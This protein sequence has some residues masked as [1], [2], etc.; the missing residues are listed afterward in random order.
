MV[1]VVKYL[2]TLLKKYNPSKIKSFAD[3]R[4]SIDS[5][6]NLYRKLGFILEK[7]TLPDYRYI[8]PKFVKRYH[9]FGFRKKTLYNKYGLPLSMTESEMVKELGYDRIWDCG[10]I[11]YVWY[12]NKT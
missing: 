10:L 6:S 12:N 9:K 11:K 4:W 2:N 8:K 7:Y 1:L 3:R 5:P